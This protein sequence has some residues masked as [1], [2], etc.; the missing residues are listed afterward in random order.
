MA[1]LWEGG[2]SMLGIPRARVTARRKEMADGRMRLGPIPRL[3][4]MVSMAVVVAI[5]V[6]VGLT[7]RRA[8]AANAA[9]APP[10]QG[11]TVTPGDLSFILKQI[12]IAERHTTTLTASNPC[13]TLVNKVGDGILPD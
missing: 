7:G 8:D 9:V 11:F 4:V 10:G 13:G 1:P 12:K 3:I 6:A 5:M 2:T